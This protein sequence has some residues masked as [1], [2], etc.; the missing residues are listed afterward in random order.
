[1]SQVYKEYFLLV[2]MKAVYIVER[3]HIPQISKQ[4]EAVMDFFGHVTQHAGSLVPQPGKEPVAPA[5][6]S[7]SLIHWTA[8]EVLDFV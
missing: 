8:R 5:V 6:E 2:L 3:K 4:T 7:W 1:M